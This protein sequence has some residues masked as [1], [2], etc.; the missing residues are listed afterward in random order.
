MDKLSLSGIQWIDW[1][2]SKWFCEKLW[3]YYI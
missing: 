1:E 2:S 3:W